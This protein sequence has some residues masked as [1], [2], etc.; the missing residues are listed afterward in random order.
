[1][2]LKIITT[3]VGIH[4]TV[5]PKEVD[6]IITFVKDAL[7]FPCA[8]GTTLEVLEVQLPGKK[9]VRAGQK[10]KRLKEAI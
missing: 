6:D 5:L 10:L 4:K 8:G 2:E 1:M 3:R 7:V 9:V